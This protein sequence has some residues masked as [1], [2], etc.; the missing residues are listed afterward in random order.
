[1]D[2]KE[3]RLRTMGWPAILV[4]F[5]L[6]GALGCLFLPLLGTR[7]PKGTLVLF[8]SSQLIF[9]GLYETVVDGYPFSMGFALNYGILVV[10]QLIILASLASFFGRNHPRNLMIA[11]I[12]VALSIVGTL[13]VPVLVSWMNPGIDP[14]E[15]VYGYGA[16]IVIGLLFVSLISLCVLHRLSWSFWKKKRIR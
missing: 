9:G 8:S 1:M 11:I 5:L 13:L 10:G 4:G 6:L 3:F 14:K 16:L 2:R 15:C 7:S 12:L